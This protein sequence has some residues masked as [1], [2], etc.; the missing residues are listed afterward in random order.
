MVPSNF[1]IGTIRLF[2]TVKE[3]LINHLVIEEALYLIESLIDSVRRCRR[4][5]RYRHKEA[6]SWRRIKRSQAIALKGYC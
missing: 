5:D 1:V 3:K 2:L 4:T 6:G